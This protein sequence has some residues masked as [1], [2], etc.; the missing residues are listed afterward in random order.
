MDDFLITEQIMHVTTAYTLLKLR[1]CYTINYETY[2]ISNAKGIYTPTRDS[3]I[4][5]VK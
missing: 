4:I 3:V 5:A 2:A 1:E